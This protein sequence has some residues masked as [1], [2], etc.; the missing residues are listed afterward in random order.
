MEAERPR[1]RKRRE[2]RHLDNERNQLRCLEHSGFD[3][4][5]HWN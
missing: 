4:R 3:A 1:P 2:E 5:G